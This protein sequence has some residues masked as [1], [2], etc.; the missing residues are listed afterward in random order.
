[1]TPSFVLTLK[2]NTT[3][4]DTAI[5]NKRFF[6]G[7]M[8][9]NTICR[10][11]AKQIRKLRQNPEY[12]ELLS[13]TIDVSVRKRLCDIRTS[14]GLNK[15]QLYNFSTKQHHRYGAYVD[16]TAVQKIAGSVWCSCEKVLFNKG[17]YLHFHKYEDFMSMEGTSNTTGIKYRHGHMIWNKLIVPVQLDKADIYE[18][19]A[20]THKIK[21]CRVKRIPMGTKYHY[22]LQL[23]IEG[24]PPVKHSYGTDRVGIDI[25]TSTCAVVSESNI[26]LFTLGEE[27]A[28]IGS[29]I[30]VI[31]RKLDRS[32][33][34][35]DPQNYNA[36]G[37]IKA[38]R[39]IWHPSNNYRKLRFQKKTL[40]TKRAAV[41]KQSHE[42]NANRV[43][44]LG[45][46][47]FVEQMS[48]TGLQRRANNTTV[49]KHGRCNSKKRFGTSLKNHAPSMFLDI[50]NRKLGYVG[51]SLNKV[52]TRTFRASQY[53][54]I[55]DSYVKKKLSQRWTYVTNNID[56][57]RDLYS[58][59]L[60]M[61]SNDDLQSTNR[62]K[63]I[64]TFDSFKN[65]HDIL[66][67]QLSTSTYKLP[68]SFGIT[69]IA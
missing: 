16:S 1:M 49:N 38:G 53:N 48:F 37:T 35:G 28:S 25:G 61:N 11:A 66:I 12:Q 4:S 41:L 68:S 45:T 46:K 18:R 26:L 15:Y 63:C 2:L 64:A 55:T 57:Q 17:K 65:K 51:L 19:E 33:R 24:S 10:Y 3:S 42:Q 50:I 29:Q 20:L 43:L 32:R 30:A 40:A 13:Q 59:F 54:H 21:Y 58:A 27:V 7:M 44:S 39:K 9:Y 5:L 67:Q 36:D 47:V 23:I 52:N 31:E 56:I 60:L 14:Y 34:A 22:Y 8:I 62:D 69:T 6:C